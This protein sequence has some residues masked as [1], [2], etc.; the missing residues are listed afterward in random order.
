MEWHGRNQVIRF[1]VVNME[2]GCRGVV[3]SLNGWKLFLSCGQ[4]VWA[5]M[6]VG[7]LLGYWDVSLEEQSGVDGAC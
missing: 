6:F 5:I 7:S 2:A 3:G 4:I 1:V